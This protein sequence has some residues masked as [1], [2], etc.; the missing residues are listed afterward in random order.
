[1]AES[2]FEQ[3]LSISTDGRPFLVH[4]SKTWLVDDEGRRLRPAAGELG[5][6]RPG[7]GERDVELV[8]AHPTGVVE[9][10]YGEVVFR[11]V[12]LATDHVATT[13]TA[14]RVS[15]LSRL[16]GLVDDDLA[17]AADMAAVDQ[18]LQPHFSALLKRAH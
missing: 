10:Y 5:F 4:S 17:Y 14:K 16:Y 8:L 3:E 1:M 13:A 18:P 6:W 12:E 9:L 15:G 11:K 2:R 7:A